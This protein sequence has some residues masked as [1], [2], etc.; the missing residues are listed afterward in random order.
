LSTYIRAL[1]CASLVPW[2]FI[3]AYSSTILTA[4]H[5]DKM[6]LRQIFFE[7][8]GFSCQFLFPKPLHIH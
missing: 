6:T 7:Y 5:S 1:K 4:P 2:L 3:F 8:F